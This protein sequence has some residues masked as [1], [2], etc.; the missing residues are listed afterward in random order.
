MC[1]LHRAIERLAADGFVHQPLP[2][3]FTLS[4]GNTHEDVHERGWHSDSAWQP[5]RAA[6]AGKKS[7]VRLRQSDQV[8]TI[9]SDTQI[10]GEREL[11]STGQARAGNGGDYWFWH[12]LAQRHGLV[13]ESP[14]V[15]R[16]LGP[17]AA[18]S[19]QELGDLNKRRNIKMTIEITERASG[20]D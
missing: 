17:L 19:A 9:L 10:A 11:E 14:V 7:K 3:G 1:N 4:E 18:G 2:F 20:H 5:L 12:A 16:V 6:G 15:G 13:E 8:V